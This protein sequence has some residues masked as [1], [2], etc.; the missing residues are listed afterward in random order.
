[1]RAH[2]AFDAVWKRNTRQSCSNAAFA[3]SSLALVAEHPRVKQLFVDRQSTSRNTTTR[4]T[5]G[6]R[7]RHASVDAALARPSGKTS[8]SVPHIQK[9]MTDR[10]L[11]STLID[12]EPE[13][14]HD[15]RQ[16]YLVPIRPVPPSGNGLAPKAP[17]TIPPSKAQSIAAWSASVEPPL[18]D[19]YGYPAAPPPLPPFHAA[20]GPPSGLVHEDGPRLLKSAM[21]G[22]RSGVRAATALNNGGGTGGGRAIA[23]R[24]GGPSDVSSLD[25]VIDPFEPAAS[26]GY[27]AAS[28]LYGNW[29]RDRGGLW[30]QR[31]ELTRRLSLSQHPK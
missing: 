19:A 27:E 18:L 7:H 10:S 12:I 16:D 11:S 6:R 13:P 14:V 28:R 2:L 5:S 8:V 25:D 3:L 21:K 4:W 24:R 31:L 29:V 9:Y 30:N 26:V 1:M 17:K 23:G 15:E 22:G 20:P